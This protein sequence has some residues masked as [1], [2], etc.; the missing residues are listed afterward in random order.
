MSYQG[1]KVVGVWMDNKHAFIIRTPDRK[2]G[3]IYEMV[4]KVE[5]QEHSDENYKN[6]RFEL[7]K[8]K[9][10]LKKYFKTLMD[11]IAQDDAIFI[12]GPGKAQEEFKNVLKDNNSFKSKEIKVGSSDKI[13]ISVMLARVKEHFE[14]E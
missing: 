7:A 12:F 14:A 6:E 1:K 5:R 4:K 13:S 2:T 10:E 8:D 3:G 9:M 11:D